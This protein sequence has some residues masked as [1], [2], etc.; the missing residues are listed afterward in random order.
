[1]S[2]AVDAALQ[3]VA[4]EMRLDRQDSQLQKD[5]QD[6]QVQTGFLLRFQLPLR[7]K[8][9]A[10]VILANICIAFLMRYYGAKLVQKICRIKLQMKF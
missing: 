8:R 7:P 9:R 5:L 6:G 10:H 4:A 3:R 1:M 2:L